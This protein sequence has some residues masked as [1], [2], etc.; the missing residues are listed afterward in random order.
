MDRKLSDPEARKAVNESL[1]FKNANAECK[2]MIRPLK[3]RSAPTD[4]W[5]R[6]MTD[7]RPHSYDFNERS[8]C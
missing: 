4:E 2:R 5:I 8:D 3:V 6:N 1:A 7:I